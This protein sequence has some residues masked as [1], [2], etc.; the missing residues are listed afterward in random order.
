MRLETS[1]VTLVPPNAVISLVNVM[2]DGGTVEVGLFG[3]E[4]MTGLLSAL[5]TERRSGAMSCT[6]PG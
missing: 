3:R 6:W 1:S 5:V 2:E 4:G